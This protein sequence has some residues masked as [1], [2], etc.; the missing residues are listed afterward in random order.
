MR[1]GSTRPA[2][3]N[4]PQRRSIPINALQLAQS[5]AKAIDD[6]KGSSIRIVD[7]RGISPLTDFVVIASASS[8]PHLKALQSNVAKQLRETAGSAAYRSSGD[9]E[10]AWIVMDY[11]DVVV[12]LFLPEA[13]E[14]YDIEALWDKGTDVP[15]A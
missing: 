5:A 1:T 4:H 8:A 6:K 13:R 7:V 11:F 3:P 14:Y 15:P 2:D 10:S 9:S 12:H